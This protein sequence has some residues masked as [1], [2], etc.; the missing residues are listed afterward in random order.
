MLWHKITKSTNITFLFWTGC[1]LIDR[2]NVKNQKTGYIIIAKHKMTNEYYIAGHN[3]YKSRKRILDEQIDKDDI[4]FLSKNFEVVEFREEKYITEK[5]FLLKLDMLMH[6][7]KTVKE[8]YNREYNIIN[9]EGKSKEEMNKMYNKMWMEMNISLVK[10]RRIKGLMLFKVIKDRK[11][12]TVIVSKRKSLHNALKSLYRECNNESNNDIIHQILRN[13]TLDEIDIE[14]LEVKKGKKQE[15]IK[16]SNKDEEI[17][18]KKKTN[19]IKRT[20][21]IKKA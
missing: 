14:E 17:K 6:Q 12:N 3:K 2:F 5:S 19:K 9:P 16:E 21:N 15:E 7:Y 4:D 13:H 18:T 8:E 20:K 10:D 11:L 1:K